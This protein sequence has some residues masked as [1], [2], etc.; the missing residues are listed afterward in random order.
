MLL[1]SFHSLLRSLFSLRPYSN[2]TL[3]SIS[4]RFKICHRYISVIDHNSKLIHNSR[5][6]CKKINH[7]KFHWTL[8]NHVNKQ[9]VYYKT[10]INFKKIYLPIYI[11]TAHVFKRIY[12]RSHNV[13]SKFRLLLNNNRYTCLLLLHNCMTYDG[14]CGS[15]SLTAQTSK[16]IYSYVIYCV[17]IYIYN[18]RK[19]LGLIMIIFLIFFFTYY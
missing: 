16:T 10:L 8:T 3:Y 9:H 2:N 15:K 6:Y 12:K 18:L 17:Y 1:F 14:N 4:H 7:K 19:N 5:Q 13:W 11:I